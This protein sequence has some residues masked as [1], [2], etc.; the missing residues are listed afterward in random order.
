MANAEVPNMLFDGKA[1]LWRDGGLA[2]LRLRNRTMRSATWEGLADAEGRMTAP[3]AEAM[4]ALARGGVGLVTFSHTTVAPEGQA[5]VRQLAIYTDE[6]AESMRAAV[7]A[8]HAAGALC[9]LQLN[10]G[11]RF[12]IGDARV[13]ASDVALDTSSGVPLRPCR[14][15]TAA[16]LDAIVAAFRAGAAR[17]ARVG[18]DCVTVH[19]AHGYLLS[20]FLSPLFNRRTDEYGGSLENRARL[21]RRVVAACRAAV[22]PA[23]PV[24]V[25]L[26]TE[27]FAAGGLTVAESAQVAQW[28]A[29]DGVALV[30][31]SGGSIVG[32]YTGIRTG[33]A[34][35][36]GYHAQAAR[37]WRDTLHAAGLG[38]CLV[39]L[40]GGLRA[41]DACNRFLADGVCDIVALSRPLIREPDL[42]QHWQSD[43]HYVAQCISCSACHA[44][45]KKDQG[46]F[47][48]VARAQHQDS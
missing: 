8:V 7:A 44:A 11:G 19:A 41:G 9:A 36:S 17:A 46:Y 37:T 38:R 24:L 45:I 40:V 28:L 47:C 15:A 32:R 20:Q 27:D 26:N 22:G 23:V 6:Q 35:T 39:A 42:V 1:E 33:A 29:A 14:A 4:A 5:S 30:E 31:A 25:K 18:F 21:L 16:D 34:A 10:H 48:P 2:P 3:L 12:A 43:P 13:G